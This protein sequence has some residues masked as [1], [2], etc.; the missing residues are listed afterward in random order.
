MERNQCVVCC[1]NDFIPIINISNTTTIVSTKEFESNEIKQLKFIGC[2][3]C[4]C[5]QLQNLFLQNII[6]SQPLEI[7]NGP[8]IKKHRELFC[9]FIINNIN[10]EPL[11]FEIGGSYGDLAKMIIN[12]YLED[13]LYVTYKIL[14]YSSEN[15]PKIEN[16]E[17][18]SGDCET[19]EYI[20]INTIIMSHVFEHLYNPREFIEKIS[21]TEIKNVFISIPD[22]DDLLKNGDINNLNIL[23]TFYINTQYIV[24]LFNEYGFSIEN[25]Y[26]YKCNSNFYFFKKNIQRSSVVLLDEEGSNELLSRERI[27]QYKNKELLLQHKVV[28]DKFKSDI[29]N[30]H[31]DKPFFICPSGF[32]GQFVYFNLNKETVKNVIGFLDGDIFKIDKRLCGTPLKI[33]KKSQVDKYDR[34]IVLIS[35]CKHNNEIQDELLLYNKNIQ[36]VTPFL[37]N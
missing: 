16:L 5:V 1:K 20:G 14:E 11:L 22:M 17:Y 10:Y 30:I 6:Y 29:N 33:F 37:Y 35:S 3:E 32:Y 9:D 24:Y 4:G 7:F 34:I 12:K 21:N 25:M 23:H 18:I 19:Y 26:N 2:V 13:N 27:I 28:Y 8:I 15:Y 36:F 31:I